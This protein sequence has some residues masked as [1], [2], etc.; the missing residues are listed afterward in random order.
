[1]FFLYLQS[2]SASR[3]PTI[4]NL[5]FFANPVYRVQSHPNTWH[6]KA[7]QC[8]GRTQ[9]SNNAIIISLWTIPIF[10]WKIFYL[11]LQSS[12]ASRKWKN[13]NVVYFADLVH[14]VQRDPSMTLRKFS[15]DMVFELLN[16]QQSDIFPYFS[17]KNTNFYR[18]Y[19]IF[20]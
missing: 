20:I 12:S 11:H 10:R 9:S 2:S 18:K 4:S 3:Q 5:M 15:L 8:H 6:L 16:V 13:S 1:M 17:L 7:F 19:F 14:R